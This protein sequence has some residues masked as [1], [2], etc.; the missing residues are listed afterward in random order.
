[1]PLENTT[2]FDITD[3]VDLVNLA[4]LEDGQTYRVS[5]VGAGGVALAEGGSSAPADGHPFFPG[6]EAKAIPPI[7]VRTGYPWWIWS[8][9][10]GTRV[11]VSKVE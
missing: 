8:L 6:R 2:G 3:A 11:V 9:G 5:I 7:K 10:V 1:M 4:D